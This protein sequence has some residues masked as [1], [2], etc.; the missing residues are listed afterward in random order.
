[1]ISPDFIKFCILGEQFYDSFNFVIFLPVSYFRQG[2]FVGNFVVIFRGFWRQSW[3]A[4][5]RTV[6]VREHRKLQKEKIPPV[7]LKAVNPSSKATC[8]EHTFPKRLQINNSYFYSL[9]TLGKWGTPAATEGE[10]SKS[11]HREPE[12]FWRG[13]EGSV[14]TE[15][16]HDGAVRLS[17]GENA[18]HHHVGAPKVVPDHFAAAQVI[19]GKSQMPVAL[20]RLQQGG[21][22]VRPKKLNGND[23]K[24]KRGFF[25]RGFI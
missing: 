9:R 3:P 12:G 1:M 18:P 20:V 8:G 7:L 22:G 10:S 23:N 11:K 16:P 5:D 2:R 13:W 14:P 24:I 25:T 6:E 15:F 19:H 4:K 17:V 21:V